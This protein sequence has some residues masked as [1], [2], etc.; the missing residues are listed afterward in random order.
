MNASTST[1]SA[2]RLMNSY[3]ESIPPNV[4]APQTPYRVNLILVHYF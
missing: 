3:V 2:L 4:L 1:K